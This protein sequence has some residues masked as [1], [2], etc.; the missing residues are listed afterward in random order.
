[1]RHL[2]YSFA[3]LSVCLFNSCRS[4]YQVLNKGVAGNNSS[5]LLAR[6]D[7]DVVANKPDLVLMMVGTNDMVNSGKFMST[8]KY[9]DNL[10]SIIQKIKT[11][12]PKVHIVVSS[13]LPVEEDYLFKR[14]DPSKFP[15]KPNDK[16][17]ALNA[18]L[19]KFAFDQKLDFIPLNEEFKKYGS[20][21]TIKESLLVNSKN[22]TVDDGVHPTAQGYELIGKYFAQQLKEKKLLKRK[23][24]ILCFGDSITYGAFMEGK[25][26]AEG[27]TYPAVLLRSLSGR[28]TR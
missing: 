14:H 2:L 18:E 23:M 25:G 26:T 10:R 4:N 3:I 1:M 22:Y 5:D 12:N 7:K 8:Q 20:D 19:K 6:V 15:I 16:I 17:D 28:N 13:I 9:L 24:L 27:N 11:G 21:Y